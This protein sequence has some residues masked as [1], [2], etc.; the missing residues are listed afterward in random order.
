MGDPRNGIVHVVAPEPG[1]SKPGMT[2]VCRDSHTSIHGAFGAL[3]FGIGT[4]VVE[5]VLATQTIRQRRARNMRVTV[6]GLLPPHISARDL[7]PHRLGLIATGG[8]NGHVIEF[9]GK[10]IRALSTEARMTLC[11][12]S[13]EIGARAGLI[14]LDETTFACLQGRPGVPKDA[15]WGKAIENW[16]KLNSDDDAQFNRELHVDA[17]SVM[18]TASWCTNPSQIVAIYNYISD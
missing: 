14:A 1:R 4:S 9:A 16:R 15:A 12:L 18:P 6:D 17:A 10:A 8:A 5:H 13:I 7:A 2:K 11:N 3:S